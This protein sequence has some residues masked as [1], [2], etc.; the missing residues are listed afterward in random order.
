MTPPTE[1]LIAELDATG[2]RAFTDE[3]RAAVDDRAGACLLSAN[4]GSGKTAVM[5]ERFV[6]AV[7]ADGVPVGQVL[8]L[9]FTEKAAGELRERL[10][11]RFHER[12]EP[13]RARETDTAWVGTIHGFCARVLR[14]EPLAAGLDP[15]FAVL[16]DAAAARLAALGY[17]AAFESWVRERG[18]PALAL[19]AAYGGGLA[20]MVIGAHA[21]L[22]SEGQTTPCLELPPDAAPPDPSVLRRACAVASDALR[23]ARDGVRV[24]AA[25]EAL[26]A[27]QRLLDEGRRAQAVPTPASLGIA[28]LRTGASALSSSEC[29]EYRIAWDAYRKSCADH[30]AR[31]ALLLI[32]DLL[33]RFA[34]AY[35]EEKAVRGVVDFSDLELEVR[36]LFARDGRARDRWRERFAMIMIDEFQDTNRVQLDVLEA[37]ERDNLFAVGDEFQSIYGFRHA[38]VTI[39]RE[40]RAALGQRRVRRLT[41]NF[42]SRPELLRVLNGVFSPVFGAAF[43]PLQAGSEPPPAQTDRDPSQRTEGSVA[44]AAPVELLITDCQGWEGREEE[45]GL[46]GA[47]EQPWRRAEARWLADRI[48]CEL[49]AGRRPGDVVVLVRSTASL[50]LFEQALEERRVPTYVVGGRGYWSHEQVRDGLAYLAAL[51]NPLDEKALLAVLASP[52]CG[53][54]SD[55][56]VL[57]AEAGRRSG[58]GLWSALHRGPAEDTL[59]SLPT[60]EL[61]RLHRFRRFFAVERE[62]VE[63]LA[64]DVLLERALVGLGYDIAVLSRAGGDRRMANLR[65]L[66]RLAREYEQSESR[67]LRSF[68]D[69]AAAEALREAREGEAPLEAE[70]LDAVRLMTIHRAKGLEFPVVVVADLGRQGN[71]ATP[72]LLHSRDGRV[73]LRLATLGAGERVEALSY[74]ALA[75]EDAAAD[76]EEERRLFYVAMTRAE[77]KLI[78]SGGVDLQRLPAARP[79]GAPIGWLLPALLDDPAKSLAEPAAQ[80]PGGAVLERRWDGRRARLGL[81]VKVATACDRVPAAD[82]RPVASISGEAS[83]PAPAPQKP[84]LPPPQNAQRLSY[85]ALRSYARCGYRYYLQ[86]VLGL[87]DDPVANRPGEQPTCEPSAG[88][89]ARVHGIVAHRLLEEIDFARPRAPEA[90]RVA[91]LLRQAGAGR[92]S[93]ADV[94][95]MVGLV[96]AFC[97]S[98]LCGRLGGAVRARRE[99][100]FAFAPRPGQEP[101]IT[102]VVDVHATER[103]DRVLVVDYK[104]DRLAGRFPAEIVDHEYGLQRTVYALAALSA[105]ARDVEVA[106][107]FLERSG[108]HVSRRFSPADAPRLADELM[109]ASGGIMEGEWPVAARPHRSLCLDCPGRRTLCSHPEAL[110]LRPYGPAQLPGAV[111][112]RGAGGAAQA[113][114]ASAVSERP[115]AAVAPSVSAAVLA[116][117]AAETES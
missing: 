24:S 68:L 112:P 14:S 64:P 93:R 32:D 5:V 67:D 46:A 35:A 39:F 99:A 98:P 38:D 29:D 61:E 16:D 17:E 103:D 82:R 11:G 22:R 90:T 40:R 106:Y 114:P 45:I 57:L 104:T 36:D 60:G 4:A 105:G 86:R 115:A 116:G 92:V 89:D 7:L 91:A 102:G 77:E 1:E 71:T 111:R 51:A 81:A 23:A 74:G 33:K 30:H 79:G 20:G 63:R 73:G 117:G 49:D 37:L 3:Q 44:A 96:A 84:P 87:P 41:A 80:G 26:A 65:K 31:S 28:R 107:C 54:G 101:L 15:R 43:S 25:R 85:S 47:A 76:D 72:A 6:E 62:H 83:L 27:C 59:M 69:H 55:A 8:A 2:G 19:A 78:L 94:D 50:R 42:R 110:T 13:D 21:A 75:A 97:E 95:D 113:F 109:R 9:T 34:R 70:N 100:P 88:V 108:D 58:R 12:G 48:R 10:R 66:M 52:F 56:L 53:V 18:E